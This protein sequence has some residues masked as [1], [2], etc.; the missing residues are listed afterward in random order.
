MQLNPLSPSKTLSNRNIKLKNIDSETLTAFNEQLTALLAKVANK[1]REGKQETDLRD[2]LNDGLYADFYINK[3]DTIDWAIHH[4]PTGKEKV[5]V[6]LE[7]KSTT[8]TTEM[9][10]T[11]KPNA[12]ALHELVLYYLRERLDNAN[13]DIKH[14][15]ATN[16]HTW[17]VIDENWFDKNIFT[18]QLKKAYHDWKIAKK[19][20]DHFYKFIAKPYLE[21]LETPLTCTFVDIKTLT[22]TESRALFTLLSPEFLMKQAV[23]NDANKLNVPFY[24]EL[25]H[26]MGIEERKDDKSN[27]KIIDR[28]ARAELR[29]AGSLLENTIHQ[30]L[31]ADYQAKVQNIEQYGDDAEEQLFSVALEL[32]ITWLNRLLFLK[33][34]EG[35]LVRY[36]NGDRNYRF[37]SSDKIT[38]YD[39]LGEL[40]FDVLAEQPENRAKEVQEKFGNIPYLNSSLF[41]PSVLERSV[42]KVVELKDRL[43]IP[44][45]AQTVL[46]DETGKTRRGRAK[47]LT[48]LLDFLGAYNFG[49]SDD[50]NDKGIINAAV[51]GLIFEKLNGYK[52]GS[53]FT[54]SFITMY[55]CSQSIRRAVVAKL[56][57]TIT[58]GGAKPSLEAHRRTAMASLRLTDFAAITEHLEYMNPE[59]RKEVNN[60]INSIKICDPAVGSGHFLVSALNEL[61]AVKYDLKI[62][63]YRHSGQRVDKDWTIKVINDE[64]VITDR[65]TDRPFQYNYKNP[66]SQALQ[67]TLFEE[68]RTLIENCLFGVDINPK[69]V[70]ICQLR[71]WIEL[72]K[73]A[74]Y[75]APPAPR[76]GAIESPSSGAGGLLQ[77]LPNID[78][79]I[80]AGNSLV[81]RFG[82]D[83]DLGKVLRSIKYSAAQYRGFVNDYKN[84]TNKEQKRGLEKILTGIKANFRTEI[85]KYTNP[86]IVQL[87]KLNEEQYARFTGNALFG[88]QLSDKQIEERD[89]LTEKINVLTADINEI[90]NSKIYRNAFEWRFEF[91]EILDD[92]GNFVGFDVVVGNPPYFSL[93]KDQSLKQIASKY[94]TYSQSGDIYMLFYELGATILKQGGILN[95]I[96]GSAWLRANYGQ[97]LRNFLANNTN[98]T[99]LI[100]FSDCQIFDE[101]TVLTSIVQYTNEENQNNLKATRFGREYQAELESI[102]GFVA[103]NHTIL[104]NTQQD[105]W[106][107]VSADLDVIK[108]KVVAQG[109]VLKDWKVDIYRGLL[110]GFNEAFLIDGAT[111]ARLIDSDP[112][113]E[114]VIKP[115][116]RG[117]DI[118]KYEANFQKIW[119]IAT[120]NGEM[121]T[122]KD[123]DKDIIEDK[124]IVSVKINGNWQVV[125]RIELKGK[126]QVRINRVVAETDYPAVYEHLQNYQTELEK[127]LDK[128]DHWTNLRNCAYWSEFEKPKIVYPELT[129]FFKFS[130]DT[131]GRYIDKTAFILVGEYLE[132]LTCFFNSKLFKY[133]FE[134]DFSEIVGHTRV[135][136]KVFFETIVVKIPTETE[137]Q[138]FIKKVE[139]MLLAKKGG[140]RSEAIALVGLSHVDGFA[141]AEIDRLVYELYD[142]TEAEIEIIERV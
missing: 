5:A 141:E 70:S 51:L 61:I 119:L 75:Q 104:K 118:E 31:K 105:N 125:K 97:P 26:L 45:A 115:L 134:N 136:S 95:F 4:G 16:I 107:I 71:L 76:G 126:K 111:R 60:A 53:F 55:M 101:A 127:R 79:N 106:Q 29:N 84:A 108:Q 41:E 73:N 65:E 18:T 102:D 27:K 21:V 48:Y 93:S 129:K 80:K 89:R 96:T 133:C 135:L 138:L 137:N 30:L 13:H 74:Y 57:E 28:I 87:Q 47:T 92:N 17:F 44:F 35:Q 8:A 12:K 33:L 37:L 109:V 110:T 99:A 120:H 72:L 67:E 78:I 2:F 98:P 36:H 43:E 88:T 10:T 58:V 42:L 100:D 103:A 82:L 40:F 69:S 140:E 54:P 1:Q 142:L 62:L 114:E 63:T 38:D 68:K 3:K 121:V 25:L 132:Y 117:R 59:V 90:Q 46:Q 11:D 22:E 66:D 130:I 77:T 15:I 91:P 116:L 124:G 56:S 112:K 34:L 50:A 7:V 6:I 122:V 14:L 85:A 64:L 49:S 128:G 81:S 32:C 9:M 131:D 52:D 23:A 24:N 94:Q 113:S 86:K 20:T 139:A 83:A 39:E 19:D 123:L